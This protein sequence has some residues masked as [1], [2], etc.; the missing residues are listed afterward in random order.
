MA[1]KIKLVRNDSRPQLVVS[2]TDSRDGSPMDISDDNTIVR[3]KFRARGT[4]VLKDTL[5]ALKLPG[6]VTAD[7][8]IDYEDLTPGRGGRAYFS[9]GE[10]TL[11]GEPGDY[12]GE[13]E[14]SFADGV[15][16]IYDILKFKLREDF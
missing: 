6:V 8:T 3:M 13:I 5:V 1:E 4:T 2:L 7:G 14:I 9:W 10:T 16:T 15:Q 11:D 12:E